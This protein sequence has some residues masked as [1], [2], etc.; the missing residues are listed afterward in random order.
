MIFTNTKMFPGDEVSSNYEISNKVNT[1]GNYIGWF[2]DP[3][4][5]EDF[6]WEQTCKM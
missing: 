3:Q 4:S 5:T 2:T 1:V 6:L